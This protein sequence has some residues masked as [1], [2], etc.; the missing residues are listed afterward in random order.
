MPKSSVLAKTIPEAS[1]LPGPRVEGDPSSVRLLTSGH[2]NTVLDFL[3]ER[4]IHTVMLAGL[5]RDNGLTSP[6]NRGSFHACYDEAGRLEGVAVIGEVTTFE[7]RTDRALAALALRARTAAKIGMIIGEEERVGHFWRHYRGEGQAPPLLCRELLFELRCPVE[8][9]EPVPGLRTATLDDLDSVVKVHAEMAFAE[10]GLDPLAADP[11]GFRQRC[12]RRIEQGRVWLWAEAGR[13][14]FKADVVSDTP[15]VIYLE[16]LYVNPAERG[17]G[18]GFRCLSQLSRT[19]LSR[20]KSICLL[21]N[22]QNREAQELYRK[23]RYQLRGRYDTIFFPA[24]E[25]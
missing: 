8:V 17:R 11:Q 21:A 9:R 20:T 23:S 24:A 16:G 4:P 6:L 13:L 12:A 19:L 15:E 2:E 7:A 14:V 22:E 25:R 1:T 3:A 10:S 5:I 18:H